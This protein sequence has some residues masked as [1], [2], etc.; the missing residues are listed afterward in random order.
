MT[1][2]ISKDPTNKLETKCK[3]QL[4][5]KPNMVIMQGELSSFSLKQNIFINKH[6][7][8]PVHLTWC[9]EKCLSL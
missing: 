9:T 7:L 1:Q 8:S 4:N 3:V 5:S 6:K 2:H